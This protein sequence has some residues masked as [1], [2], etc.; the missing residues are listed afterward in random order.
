ME[1]MQ[2]PLIIL[3]SFILLFGA[4]L[5][6]LQQQGKERDSQNGNQVEENG[7]KD[8]ENISKEDLLLRLKEATQ[9]KDYAALAKYLKASYEKGWYQEQ[10]FQAAESAAYVQADNIYFIPGDYEKTLEVSTL[11]YSAVPQGWRF[12]YLRVLAL[13]KLGRLALEQNDVQGAEGYATTILQMTFRPEGANLL[14]DVYIQKIEESMKAGNLEEAKNSYLYIKDFE[15]S[16]DRRMRLEQ[17][18]DALGLI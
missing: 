1:A 15:V 5:L 13:E 16:Q 18:K 9:A 4:G 6:F 14:G 3:V 7:A 2:K 11:V 8:F 12:L 10:D 17:L